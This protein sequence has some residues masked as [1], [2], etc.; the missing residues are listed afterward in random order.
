MQ[1]RTTRRDSFRRRRRCD[2]VVR[3][4][5]E[6]AL[7]TCRLPRS[8]MRRRWHT[9][10]RDSLLLRRCRSDAVRCERARVLHVVYSVLCMRRSRHN[11]R[12]NSLLLCRRRCERARALYP[13]LSCGGGGDDMP[14]DVTAAA[15]VVSCTVL[16]R[17]VRAHASHSPL[18][19]LQRAARR[20]R[21][22]RGRVACRA[23][24]GRRTLST[25]PSST[26]Y[27]VRGG[28]G[29]NVSC[30]VTVAASA[31]MSYAALQ[32]VYRYAVPRMKRR[33]DSRCRRRG[34][35]PCAL[36]DSI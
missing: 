22:L 27:C 35:V 11:T 9:T 29:S 23:T 36:S 5:A 33:R 15:P 32:S 18:C 10:R 3:Y 1:Q 19:T 12:R 2:R 21:P 14:P 24:S 16:M 31:D 7:S 6:R 26:L 20:E 13:V 8:C 25:Y 28:G 34:I 4:A 17:H 30:D